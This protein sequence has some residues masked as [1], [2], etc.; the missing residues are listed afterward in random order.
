MNIRSRNSF[1]E[2]FEDCRRFRCVQKNQM[3]HGRIRRV[4]TNTST[5]TNFKL[6]KHIKGQKT[7]F[8]EPMQIN[9]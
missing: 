1:K 7:K 2:R 3:R 8:K 4:S 6:W 5:H 9:M